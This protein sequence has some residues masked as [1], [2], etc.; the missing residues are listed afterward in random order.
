MR[1]VPDPAS[2]AASSGARNAAE[3]GSAAVTLAAAGLGREAALCGLFDVRLGIPNPVVQPAG[4][5]LGKV[6]DASSSRRR[7]LQAT[8]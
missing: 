7:L 2:A 3:A 5:T 6:N 4:M 1:G 8:R